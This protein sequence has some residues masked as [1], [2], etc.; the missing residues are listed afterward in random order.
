MPLWNVL[1]GVPSL[2]VIPSD[3]DGVFNVIG[4]VLKSFFCR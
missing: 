4:V 3:P 1:Y 2:V